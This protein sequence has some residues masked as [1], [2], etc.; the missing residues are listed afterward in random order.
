MVDVRPLARGGE[1][2]D[3]GGRS[4]VTSP[5][6]FTFSIEAARMGRITRRFT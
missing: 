3:M 2:T 4:K 6:G 1:T 5:T